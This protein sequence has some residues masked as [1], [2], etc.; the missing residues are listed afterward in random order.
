MLRY[1]HRSGD[2]RVLDLVTLT[3]DAMARGGIYDQLGGGFHRYAVDE[4]WRVPH[5][6][7]MLYDNAQLLPLYAHAYQIT[8]SPLYARV[9]RETLAYL[10]REMWHPEGGFYATQDAD[11]EGEEG[12]FYVWRKAEVDALL[13]EASRLVCRYYDITETG[14]WEHGKNILHLTLSPEQLAS[15]FDRPLAEVTAQLEA[16]KAVLFAAREKRVKPFR[17]E[18]ILTAWNGLLLSGLLE[19]AN[20]LGET[21]VVPLVQRTFAFIERHL[22]RDGQLLRVYKDGQAKLPGYLDDYALFIAALLDAFESLGEA[23]YF[24]L[25]LTLTEV[26][27]E[28]FWDEAQ[29]GFFFTGKHHE[30]LLARPKQVFDQA[31]PA[32]MAVATHVLLRLYHLTGRA[33]YL[34]R[35]ERVLRGLASAMAQHPFGFGSLLCALDFYLDKPLEVVIMGAPQAPATQALRRCVYQH[36]LPNRLVVPLDPQQYETLLQDLP[37]LR[38]LLA[39]K[40]PINGQ[41]T[42]YVCHDF[43]CSAP[44]TDPAALAPLLRRR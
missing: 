23:R 40:A 4:R 14:N 6:E 2:Q 34:Q 10:E 9:V 20:V 29:G 33:D 28:E 11:S 32:G 17:D 24:R 26:M 37:P 8:G 12:K 43:T 25:A 16:A 1:W 39:G 27:L 18:K 41:P 35:A 30:A 7:K 44:V 15:L 38:D 22:L 21:R 36:Y 3:L 31:L 42:A 5:F 19:V 13:G